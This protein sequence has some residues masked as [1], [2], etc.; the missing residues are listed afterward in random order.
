MKLFLNVI[1]TVVKV[2]SGI[3]FFIILSDL[4]SVESFGNLGYLLTL[5][6][7]LVLASTLGLQNKL[8][9]DFS[10]NS[11]IFDANYKTVFFIL[12]ISFL[13]LLLLFSNLFFY[14]YALMFGAHGRLSFNLTVLLCFMFSTY[15]QFNYAKLNGNERYND[16]VL[17][18]IFGNLFSLFLSVIFIWYL[19]GENYQFY[20]VLF[21]PVLK[22]FVFVFVNEIKLNLKFDFT[23]ISVQKI[24]KLLN[25]ILPYV[26][27]TL[28]SVIL[29]YGFQIW[30]RYIIEKNISTLHVGYWQVIVKHSEISSLLFTS[31]SSIFLLPKIS[32]SSFLVQHKISKNFATLLFFLS[33]PALVLS[34]YISP[35]HVKALFGSEYSFVSEHLIW[36]LI[37]DVFKVLSYS[38]IM[39]VLC[40]SWVKYFIVFELTQYLILYLNYSYFTLHYGADY[41]TMSYMFSYMLYFCITLTFFQFLKRNNR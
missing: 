20:V 7:S 10:V 11:D 38:F 34:H 26:L 31:L 1:S 4:N 17:T 36:Q 15:F 37:G 2:L 29:I 32:K 16:I 9:K 14:D 40:N 41:M 19:Q 33:I 27:M 13:I 8:I 35:F 3:I 30:L 25:S 28:I 6:A 5:S 22:C 21:Y 18:N 12:F 24:N 39:I 23:S